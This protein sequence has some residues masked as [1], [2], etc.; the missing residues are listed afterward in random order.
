[1]WRPAL[2]AILLG[3]T[4]ASWH[5]L[6]RKEQP[7]RT[8]DS[9]VLGNL[10]DADEIE[11]LQL[12]R[13]HVFVADITV[14]TPPQRLS[15]LLDSGSADLWIP[16]KQCKNCGNKRYFHADQS[17]TFMPAMSHTPTGD[18]PVPVQ[19]GNNVGEIVGFLVEDT[20]RLGSVEF[21]NQSFLIVEEARLPKNRSWDGMCG[22]GWQEMT[23]AAEPLYKNLQ[24][25]SGRAIFAIVPTSLTETYLV[26][27]EVPH[28]GYANSIAWMDAE[29]VGPGGHHSF[30]VVE[31]GLGTHTS[32]PMA[33][34]FLIDTGTEFLLAPRRLY[35]HFVRS[36]FPRDA[37]DHL[38]GAD[39]ALGNLVVCDCS[40]TQLDGILREHLRMYLGGQ[41]FFLEIP[42]LFKRVPTTAGGELCLLQVQPNSLTFA[43]PLDLLAE[44][45]GGRREGNEILIPMNAQIS[46]AASQSSTGSSGNETP[47]VPPFLL[48]PFFT[49]PAGSGPAGGEEVEEVLETRP[50]GSRCTTVLVWWQGHLQSNDTKCILPGDD[51]TT[52]RLQEPGPQLGASLEDGMNDVW[53]LG[54]V[55][56][57]H[58]ITVFDFEHHRV[59][60]AGTGRASVL[61][62]PE[63]RGADTRVYLDA[64]PPAAEEQV[65]QRPP[66]FPWGVALLGIGSLS[67][68]ACASV[69]SRKMR[70]R[71]CLARQGP[72]AEEEAEPEGGDAPTSVEDP[73]GAAAE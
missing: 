39:A 17:S 8:F 20:V 61:L 15:C 22:L 29:P 68:L 23:S 28:A 59:G 52:R 54:G 49:E 34:H 10:R 50:D 35:T 44:V 13:S 37:F 46:S 4:S 45:I 43:D 5:P 72:E 67:L 36:L 33:A 56:L 60:F 69:L 57:E 1:M 18:V 38:C 48:P 71:R 7:V 55:F 70:R 19:A 41:V 14:G 40:I 24:K 9:S 3:T 58:F 47:F 63:S 16:S 30:W 73:D 6:Q 25:H 11:D 27:G 26:V 65:G 62:A 53:V 42:D 21:Q 51:Q 66:P 32:K 2:W 12:S 64:V 31:G